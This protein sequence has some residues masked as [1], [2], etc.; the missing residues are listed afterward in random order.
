MRWRWKLKFVCWWS[1]RFF[2]IHDYHLD[3]GGDGIPTHWYTYKCW[4]CGKRFGI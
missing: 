1:G 2:D 3:C 4:N